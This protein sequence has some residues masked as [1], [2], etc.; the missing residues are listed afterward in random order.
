M[1][2]APFGHRWEQFY[3]AAGQRL[4][5]EK[6]FFTTNCTKITKTFLK[7]LLP[8]P[9]LEEQNNEIFEAYNMEERHE[10]TK[11]D[12]F[13][14]AAL[15]GIIVTV[16]FNIFFFGILFW[17]F[18]N[19]KSSFEKTNLFE[20]NTIIP[21]CSAESPQS[22]STE[23]DCIDETHVSPTMSLLAS[24]AGH[25]NV[26]EEVVVNRNP[27]QP[28][29]SNLDG[30]LVPVQTENTAEI[31]ITFEIHKTIEATKMAEFIII[32]TILATETAKAS[33]DYDFRIQSENIQMLKK[34]I[35]AGNSADVHLADYTKNSN[36]IKVAVKTLKL[37]CLKADT[38]KEIKLL[39][40]CK[41][42]NIVKFIGW[43]EISDE[44]M[45]I[46]TEYMRG[47]GL[48][49]YQKMCIITE[50]M[51]GGDLHAYLTN[52]ENHPTISK[53][54]SFIFQVLNAMIY[55]HDKGIIHRDLAARNFLL[56]KNYEILKLNDFGISRETDTNGEYVQITPTRRLPFRWLPLETLSDPSVFA[57]KGDIWAF[58][59]LLWEMYQR[60]Q[61][62]YEQSYN[63]KDSSDLKHL[64]STGERLH[65]PEQCH[66][67]LYEIMLSCWNENPE[68]RPTFKLIDK[69]IHDL[70]DEII[71]YN[72][73]YVNLMVQ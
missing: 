13:A 57:Q 35:G 48:R 39:S 15:T 25:E 34:Q 26:T 23:Y 65:K 28:N 27:H 4:Q 31:T 62:P 56:N 8:S 50:Y 40:S 54:F 11:H 36:S 22:C 53:V 60:G 18:K 1:E 49:T 20:M 52:R 19:K 63:V 71:D 37:N 58:G 9:Y 33:V 16:I 61:Q 67:D 69:R 73:Q 32:K 59:V 46:L 17:Y 3:I 66:E 72:N 6:G 2:K 55:L 10:D 51:G 24:K 21:P 47:G 38:L 29:L 5:C 70:Y 44:Q 64:L 30:Y 43:M 42:E 7:P 14:T 45:C 68:E 41:H 12:F